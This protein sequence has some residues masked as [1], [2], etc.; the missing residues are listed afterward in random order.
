MQPAAPHNILV[1]HNNNDL[2]GGDKVLLELLSRLD[3]TR[4]IPLVVLP[5][6]T[7]HI[8]RFSP[9]LD[10]LGIE[11]R[12]LPL[13]IL[14]R[15]YFKLWR[16]PRFAFEV[17][18]GARALRRIIRERNIALV[19]TNTNTIFASA[20]AA[21]IARLPHIWSVHELV[22]EPALV[23]NALHFV[24]P[25]MATKVV[26]VSRAVRDHMLKD[27]LQFASRFEFILGSIDVQ[28]FLNA[29]GRAHVRK[30]WGVSDDELL[31]GMASRV[32]RWKGQSVFAEMAKL[33][34]QRHPKVR[35]AAVGGVFDT[36][37]IYMDSFK[38]QVRTL[39]IDDKFIIQDFRDDMPNVFAAFDIF[40]LPSTLPEPFGLVVIEAMAS[41]KPVVATAPGGPSETVL[42]GETGYLVKPSDSEDLAS[43]VEK[44][45][46]D[47][48]KRARMGEAGRKRACEVFALPRY[49]REFED[50]Y[51][52]L[53]AGAKTKSSR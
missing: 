45:L 9:Q 41:G 31:V 26:T 32:T 36:E 23:R 19:H 16:L 10:K 42:E 37:T 34:L 52:R 21:R 8:N 50:L 18:A 39:G 5:T 51:A 43:A 49:V 4:F 2:Y 25:R 13:G 35:F 28:P 24:I 53:I 20:I 17:L 6:D 38:E 7:R 33:V 3:R 12:F 47:P 1:V 46:D 14:R 48:A 44:L 40:V 11:Y 29:E 15:R 22:L 27:A 30:E